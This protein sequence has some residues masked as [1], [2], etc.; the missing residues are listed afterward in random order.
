MEILAD[1]W[2]VESVSSTCSTKLLSGVR[3]SE[4]EEAEAEVEH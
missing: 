2:V 4:E 3:D 1:D